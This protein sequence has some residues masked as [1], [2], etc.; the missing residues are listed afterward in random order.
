[1]VLIA[2]SPADLTRPPSPE[3]QGASEVGS[4]Y[5]QASTHVKHDAAATCPTSV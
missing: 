5:R 1:M 3:R 2:L 4:R